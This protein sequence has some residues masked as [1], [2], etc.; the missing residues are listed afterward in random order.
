MLFRSDALFFGIFSIVVKAIAMGFTLTCSARD[1]SPYLAVRVESV[2]STIF[3]CRI[4]RG[5]ETFLRSHRERKADPSLKPIELEEMTPTA[6][7]QWVQGDVEKA[8]SAARGESGAKEARSSLDSVVCKATV[9]LSDCCPSSAK[10][11]DRAS[12][13]RRGRMWAEQTLREDA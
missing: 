5:Q 7:R 4:F 3:A 1:T 9:T 6:A 8:Q 10:H 12:E 11:A 13:R 2:A